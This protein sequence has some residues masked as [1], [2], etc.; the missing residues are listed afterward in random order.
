MNEATIV[1]NLAHPLTDTHLAQMTAILGHTPDV[2]FFATQTDRSRPLVAVAHEIVETVGLSSE[3]WQTLPLVLNPPGLA[4]LALAVMA[5]LH[6]RC[7][8]FLPILHMRP[9][10]DSLPPRYE[11]AEIV[12]LQAARDHARNRR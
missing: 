12:N 10:P 6:G 3:E 5:E 9:V 7:G 2:R 4:P 11:V 8:Y 1:V